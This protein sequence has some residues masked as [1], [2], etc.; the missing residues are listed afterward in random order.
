MLFT[1]EM[2]FAWMLALS[3]GWPNAGSCPA[4]PN[5][6]RARNLSSDLELYQ[7]STRGYC[8]AEMYSMQIA[9]RVR[10]LAEQAVSWHEHVI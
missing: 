5:P 9:L 3:W 2:A 7:H 4:L 8:A 10:T 1:S 6:M